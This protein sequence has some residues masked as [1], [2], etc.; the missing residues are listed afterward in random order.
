MFLMTPLEEKL[1]VYTISR[2]HENGF[3]GL[4][5][6]CSQMNS[7]FIEIL[8]ET[9]HSFEILHICACYMFSKF[10]EEKT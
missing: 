2:R 6:I 7:K 5:S 8:K 3:V 4:T 10:H 9:L 1:M